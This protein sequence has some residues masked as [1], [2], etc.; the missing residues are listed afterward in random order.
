MMVERTIRR[1]LLLFLFFSITFADCNSDEGTAPT[2]AD[3]YD[4]DANGIP[5]IA[6]VNYIELEKVYSISKF[7]SGVGH[8]YSDYFE[9][10]RSMK[11]YFQPKSN[12]D[13]SS[14]KLFSPV[15]GK[16]S[17]TIEEWAGTQVQIQSEEYPAFYFIIF[18]VNL[19][20]PLNVGDAVT[21]G[22]QLGT[23]I[24]SQTWSDI[25]VGINTPDGW[26][27]ISYFD[28]INDTVFK[29]YETRGILSRNELIIYEEA[30][31]ADPL[32]CT[33]GE[34]ENEGNLENWVT[35]N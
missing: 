29:E 17:N 16:V 5:K 32:T 31:D 24:G 30:R 28:I 4:V 10:C 7:R 19:T 22:Q 1:Y 9:T 26:K 25:A 21:A 14:I 2:S 18:H 27:L 35:L 15:K 13:W 12:A 20:N 6:E 34:F 23:H 33:D 3:T 8:D 11:H